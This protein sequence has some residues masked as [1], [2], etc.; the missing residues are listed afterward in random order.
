MDQAILKIL[1]EK[2]GEDITIRRTQNGVSSTVFAVDRHDKTDYLRIGY[3]EQ[4]SYHLD[5]A[6]AE[7]LTALGAKIPR[8]VFFE[9]FNNALR[10]S[11]ILT[12]G[13]PGEPI[14]GVEVEDTV[15]Y[16]AG[17]D[18]AKLASI[19]AKGFGRISR[20]QGDRDFVGENPNYCDLLKNRLPQQTE[21]LTNLGL[22]DQNQVADLYAILEKYKSH[23]EFAEGHLANGDFSKHH[24]FSKD[25]EYTGIIDFGDL[26]SGSRFYDLATYKIYE[27]TGFEALLE[28]FRS[29]ED[30]PEDFEEIINYEI[31]FQVLMHTAWRLRGKSVIEDNMGDLFMQIAELIKRLR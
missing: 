6:L 22:L 23:P 17:V 3:D 11:I 26:S 25:G 30:L 20:R 18:I 29:V 21:V 14:I 10:R 2:L 27:N 19:P 15:L 8:T 5:T 4:E 24:I 28:G 7:R 31:I 13:I 12:T 9:E 1:T 16:D